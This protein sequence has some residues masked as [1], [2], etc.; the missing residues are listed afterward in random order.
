MT[1]WDGGGVAADALFPGSHNAHASIVWAV[2][3]YLSLSING[4]WQ[5]TENAEQAVFL[6]AWNAAQNASLSAYARVSLAASTNLT[7]DSGLIL[8]LRF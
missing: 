2:D 6:A 8:E 4:Y 1:T 3:D 7:A 5:V